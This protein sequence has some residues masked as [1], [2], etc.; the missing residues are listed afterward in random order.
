MNLYIFILEI[1][2]NFE[3]RNDTYCHDKEMNSF[4]AGPIL[5]KKTCKLDADCKGVVHW[6]EKKSCYKRSLCNAKDLRYYPGL[7][8]YI[9]QG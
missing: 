4:L 2:A 7:D 9:R 3:V 5:C 6:A 8:T 1:D